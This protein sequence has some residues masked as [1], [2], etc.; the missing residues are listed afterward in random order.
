[1]VTKAAIACLSPLLATS[2]SYN[3]NLLAQTPT[4]AVNATA[5]NH[6]I[7]R[8][9]YGI[10]NYGLTASFGEEIRVPNIRWVG[11]GASRYNWEMDSS[12]SGFDWY[13]TGGNGINN[14][15]AGGQVDTMIK[16]F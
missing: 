9:I 11:D 16:K 12:D 5:N 3:I 15:V 8:N 13:F 7:N 10:A 4:L 1:M 6:A 14:P 2:L